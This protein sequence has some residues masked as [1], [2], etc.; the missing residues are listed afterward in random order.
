MSR[1]DRRAEA[2]AARQRPV[3]R[4]PRKRATLSFVT[5]LL[6]GLAL[7]IALLLAG[8]A[9]SGYA[10]GSTVNHIEV[11]LP[12]GRVVTCVAVGGS[13]VDCDWDGAR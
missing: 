8:C 13:S 12:D 7:P 6:L 5:G 2:R 1:R 10:S 11:D 9:N 3:E 4:T